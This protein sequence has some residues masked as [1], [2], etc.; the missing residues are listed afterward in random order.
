MRQLVNTDDQTACTHTGWLGRDVIHDS[1][2]AVDLVRD[3]ARDPAEHLRREHEPVRGHKVLGLDRAQCDNLLVRPLVALHADRT[4]GQEHRER[5]RDLVV[6]ARRADLLEVDRIRVLQD[7]YLLAGHWAEDAD[8]E[9]GPRKR[10]PL[11]ER[12]GDG[13]QAPQR[14]DLVW[15]RSAGRAPVAAATDP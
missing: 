12:C 2:H 1:V 10:V 11:D 14:A 15:E 9:A 6:Q 4:D 13:E 7:L 8:C 5:L 3:T